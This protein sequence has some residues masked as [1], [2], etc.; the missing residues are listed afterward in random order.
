MTN[1]IEKKWQSADGQHRKRGSHRVIVGDCMAELGGLPAGYFHACMTSPPYF[2]LRSYVAADSPLKALEIGSEPTPDEFVATMVAV[3]REVGRVLRDDGFLWINFGDSYNAGTS[4]RRKASFDNDVG[5][6]QTGGT[7][8]DER[9]N[10]QGMAAGQ[11]LLMPHRVALALQADGWVLRDTVIWAKRSPMPS[12]QNGV[13][14]ERCRVKIGNEG[15]TKQT[16]QGPFPEN[17]AHRGNRGGS[18]ATEVAKWAP[19]PGCKKCSANGGYVLRRGQGRTTTAHEYL[20]LFT[21]TNSYFWDME[22]AREPQAESSKQ[23]FGKNKSL[24]CGRGDKA[25]QAEQGNTMANSD[26]KRHLTNGLIGSRIPRSVWTG[27]EPMYRLRD[28][29]TPEQRERVLRRLSGLD[30]H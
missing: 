4:A 18:G 21:K 3:F 13:R 30:S 15:P 17:A 6:W 2:A 10:V 29:I 19:C 16:T 26:Y 12:S 8:G 7:H 27:D 23:R 22:N 1:P 5:G 14:F 20:F 24:N 11:Q 28:D 9:V 25:G